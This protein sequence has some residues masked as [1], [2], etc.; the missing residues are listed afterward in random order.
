MQYILYSIL[1][2][3][4]LAMQFKLHP[5]YGIS[6]YQA[7]VVNY[8]VCFALA[9]VLTDGWPMTSIL[10]HYDWF[11]YAILLGLLFISGFNI[12][13]IT[14]DVAGITMAS[15]FQKIAMV[16]PVAL[17]ILFFGE[18][19]G[20][21]KLSGLSIAVLAILLTYEKSKVEPGLKKEKSLLEF[22]APALTFLIGGLIDFIFYYVKKLDMVDDDML[23]CGVSFGFAALFGIL[24][25]MFLYLG[26]GVEKPNKQSLFAGVLL[27]IPN[28]F[29]LY[30][31]LRSLDVGIEGS[32][33]FP[34]INIGI[35]LA[36]T[37]AGILFFR[38]RLS[39][40]KRLA[41]GLAVL[42]ILLI[43]YAG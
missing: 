23:F 12:L 2:I 33:V 16:I 32:I 27:G 11:P 14:I 5:R 15:V 28:V 37:M 35:I 19:T 30:Y 8:V 17:A 24:Y 26:R 6:T 39:G 38:E 3:T 36:S 29:S 10:I 18:S 21:I 31:V 4:L 13:A 7:I 1:L 43:S 22:L 41:I 40:N 34:L 9:F 42:S 25:W 20:F